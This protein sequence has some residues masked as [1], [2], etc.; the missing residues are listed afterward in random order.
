MDRDL[1]NLRPLQPAM[2]NNDARDAAAHLPLSNGADSGLARA[3]VP[4]T[5]RDGDDGP[6]TSQDGED[7]HTVGR[8]HL[9]LDCAEASLEVTPDAM[10]ARLIISGVIGGQAVQPITVCQDLSVWM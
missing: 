9:Q 5:S 6:A 1:Q 2:T 8:A 7:G 4:A 3:D 10:H